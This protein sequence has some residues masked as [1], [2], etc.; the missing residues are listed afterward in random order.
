MYLCQNID[1]AEYEDKTEV[2]NKNRIIVIRIKS[3]LKS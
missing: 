3:E 2:N 1:I